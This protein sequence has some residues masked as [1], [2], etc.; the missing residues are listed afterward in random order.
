MEESNDEFEEQY[1]TEYYDDY[2]VDFDIGLD[3]TC[4]MEYAQRHQDSLRSGTEG[5][6]EGSGGVILHKSSGVP[7]W[8]TTSTP[9]SLRIMMIS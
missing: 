1:N 4:E 2:S 8:K 5:H 3:S 7:P 9:E 6:P